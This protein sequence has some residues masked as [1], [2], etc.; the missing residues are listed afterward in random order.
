MADHRHLLRRQFGAARQQG[1]GE[2][3]KAEQDEARGGPAVPRNGARAGA[4][5]HG[6]RARRPGLC[7]KERSG[8]RPFAH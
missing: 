8:V 1:I 7:L 2:A 4:G 5:C 6:G 3:G